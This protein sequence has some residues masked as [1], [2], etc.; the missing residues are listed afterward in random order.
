MRLPA[1]KAE[2]G[3]SPS[4][5]SCCCLACCCCPLLSCPGHREPH[6]GLHADERDVEPRPHRHH[7][8]VQAGA[9]TQQ[10][11]KLSLINLV[12]LAGSEKAGQTGASG[13]RLKE[14]CAINKSLSALGNVIEKLADRSTGKAKPNVVIPYRDSKLTRLLQNALGGS[15]K[16]V[17]IC[18]I[19]P[20]SSNYEETLSTLRY[21]DR[22][23]RIKNAAVIN[24]NPQDKLI[25]Q[26]REENNKLREMM[27]GKAHFE[28]PAAV[29]GGPEAMLA[30][31]AEIKALE[32]ALTNMSTDFQQ[33]LKEAQMQAEMQKKKED[34]TEK[35][36]HIA[37]LNEDQLLTNKLRFA[38]KEGR[39]RIGKASQ[40]GDPEVVLSGPGICEA[41]HA[42]IVSEGAR[43]VVT[44]ASREARDNTFV[45]GA[46]LAEAGAE[47]VALAHGDRLAFGQSLFFFV[48][49]RQGK[50]TQLLDSGK[51]SYEMA[52]KELAQFQ[53]A[54]TGPSEEELR[55]SRERA[56][57]LERRVREAEEAKQS[58][59]AQAESLM[60]QREEDHRVRCPDDA[61][62]GRVGEAASS[63]S[64]PG[65][66]Q[67]GRGRGG[68]GAAAG[69]AAGEAAGAAAGAAAGHR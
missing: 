29:G 20:A 12:D 30:K 55:A 2:G 18:A 8:R 60:R 28:S 24:E 32:E 33:R 27:G 45:N 7:H 41:E 62:A 39:T 58:A 53:A 65:G 21:A 14:G 52:R 11:C 36:P 34:L 48:D 22:A 37:N 51:V 6:G 17:M 9:R 16:T 57:A 64:R 44:A 47:G 38:L 13:D 66:L 59:K 40:A 63:A 1:G 46:S 49:P 61:E 19:S 26:L 4:S 69:G 43:C 54:G 31:Q 3:S 67:P 5:T 10:G 23:K 42:V 25:R 68:P 15:S 35:L 50:A 56:E